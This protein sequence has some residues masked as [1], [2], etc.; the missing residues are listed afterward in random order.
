MAA[1]GK[2]VASP[3]VQQLL[4]VPISWPPTLVVVIDTEEEFDWEAPFDPTNNS[5]SNM[6]FQHLAQSVFDA[7]GVTPT[8]VVD[9][10]VASTPASVAVLRTFVANGDAKSVRI[11]IL[12]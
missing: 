3:P 12:G 1:A 5:V 7:H 11:S 6:Q 2:S 10:P 4:T 9:Y 8:Y